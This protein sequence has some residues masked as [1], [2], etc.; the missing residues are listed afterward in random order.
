MDSWKRPKLNIPKTRSEWVWDIIGY[1][2]F[3]GSIILLVIFWGNLPDEVP[4]HY[5]ASGEVDRWGSKWELII[6]PIS[7]IFMLLLI[8]TLEKFPELHNYP[9]R[10]NESN[11]EQFYLNSRKMINQIKNI[12]LILFGLILFESAAIA[13]GWVSGFGKWFLPMVL[14]GTVVPIISSLVKQSKIK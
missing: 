12:C 9:K 5:N 4:A 3:F 6:L 11:A 7:G 8:Q 2:F 13:L 1:S 14:I 10:L